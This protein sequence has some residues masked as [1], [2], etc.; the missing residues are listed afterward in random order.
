M[1]IDGN[2]FNYSGGSIQDSYI[3]GPGDQ[4]NIILQGGKQGLKRSKVNREGM[5]IYD[6]AAPISAS[7]KTLGEIKDLINNIVK[8][9]L[10]ETTSYVT[11]G[12]VKQIS[13]TV[14]GEVN[15]PGQINLNGL[16]TIFEAL[17]KVGGIKKT[18]SLRNIKILTDKKSEN[19]DLYPLIFGTQISKSNNQVLENEMIIIVPPIHRTIAIDGDT[20]RKGI[21]ELTQNEASIEE[22]LEMVG[23]DKY[24]E[25]TLPVSKY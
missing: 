24:F 22:I 2:E 16:S 15:L 20:Y 1:N 25:N 6:F 13:V 14:T 10:L 7:G 21:Y 8:S 19:F 18:G 4:V 12:R 5:L 17:K 11:L 9:S 3:L 23:E